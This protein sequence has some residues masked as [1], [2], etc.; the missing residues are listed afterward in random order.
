MK[1]IAMLLLQSL[2]SLG[3]LYDKAISLGRE[4]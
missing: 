1:V 4:K 2:L 3:R